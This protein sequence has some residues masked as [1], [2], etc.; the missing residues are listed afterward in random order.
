MRAAAI[1]AHGGT[2][3]VAVI[4]RPD[5][6]PG[7]GQALVE[8][9]VCALNRLDL[10]V[11]EGMPGL[12]VDLPRIPGS[13][14]AGVVR[15]VG[16]GVGADWAGRR[17]LI[18]PIIRLPGGR[19]GAMGEHADGNMRTLTAVEEANLVALPDAVSLEAAAT[20]PIA[21]GTAHRMLFERGRLAADELVLILGASGGVGVACVQLAKAA[22]ARVIACAS[23]PW[24]LEKLAALG[25]DH[26]VNTAEEDFSAAAW[27]HS[28]KRGVDVVVNYTGGDTWV[29]AIK[30]LKRGGR[31]L[32]C[33]ATASFDPPTDLRY[34]WTRELNILGSNGWGR[35][36]ILA[37]L[38]MVADGR[39]VPVIDRVLPLDEAGAAF[40]AMRNREAL[41]KILVRP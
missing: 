38:D 32:T 39:L 5:P 20:L 29:P 1:L 19:A 15:M 33:G 36:D 8:I 11:L 40:A 13:D 28:G 10:F 26:L 24:K 30:A 3:N 34:I 17:V 27:R 12:P 41:G 22:G 2:E 23:A 21:Y 7:P 6:V 18:D 35:G 16:E 25:A 37:L 9:A 14:A 4:E 31:V